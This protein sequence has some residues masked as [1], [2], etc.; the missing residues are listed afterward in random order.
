M[1]H[2]LKKADCLYI[3][4][5]DKSTVAK[6]RAAIIEACSHTVQVKNTFEFARYEKAMEELS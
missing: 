5:R 6:S 4:P 2:A 3:A 1:D